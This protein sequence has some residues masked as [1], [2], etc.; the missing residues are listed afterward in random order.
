MFMGR[1]IISRGPH[2]NFIRAQDDCEGRQQGKGELE[3]AAVVGCHDLHFQAPC[4]LVPGSRFLRMRYRPSRGMA[5]QELGEA[6]R[7]VCVAVRQVLLTYERSRDPDE[8]DFLIYQVIKLY[9][10]PLSV[11]W[12]DTSILYTRV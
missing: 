6:L 5:T 12:C 9:R 8:L 1:R 10:I 4:S 7:L 11:D 3:K 2:S